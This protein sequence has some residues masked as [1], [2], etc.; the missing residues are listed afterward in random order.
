MPQWTISRKPTKLHTLINFKETNKTKKN[1]KTKYKN[2]K[3]QNKN[4]KI[5]PFSL[6]FKIYKIKEK[7]VQK[8]K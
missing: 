7:R 1:K 8:Q 5:N 2:K 4:Y 6:K 3:K